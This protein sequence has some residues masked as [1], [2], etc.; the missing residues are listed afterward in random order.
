MPWSRHLFYPTNKPQLDGA[1]SFISENGLDIQ[2]RIPY[3]Y[4]QSSSLAPVQQLLP[5]PPPAAPQPVN[6]SSPLP[7]AHIR[8]LQLTPPQP[9]PIE[10]L[11]H[12]YPLNPGSDPTSEPEPEPSSERDP[13]SVLPDNIEDPDFGICTN[14]DCIICSLQT[15][16]KVGEF[17][18]CFPAKNSFK[19]SCEMDHWHSRSNLCLT[20]KDNIQIY[21]KEYLILNVLNKN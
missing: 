14:N 18:A 3:V 11:M 1:G 6:P 13:L 15:V 9:Q 16:G 2:V 21:V 20:I 10:T 5:T 12:G 17:Y 7:E 8:Q 4:D 19:E